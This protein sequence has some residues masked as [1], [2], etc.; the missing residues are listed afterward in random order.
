LS[1]AVSRKANLEDMAYYRKEV[2]AKLDRVELEAF[3]QEFVDRVTNFDQ[4]L[5]ERNQILQ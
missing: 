2:G 1:T 4:K 3:R 5:L